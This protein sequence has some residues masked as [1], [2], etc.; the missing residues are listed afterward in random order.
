[1]YNL[2]LTLN[3]KYIHPDAILILNTCKYANIVHCTISNSQNENTPYKITI[4]INIMIVTQVKIVFLTITTNTLCCKLLLVLLSTA[5]PDDGVG[6]NEGFVVELELIEVSTVFLRARI[7]TVYNFLLN[8]YKIW[9]DPNNKIIMHNID[10][11][12]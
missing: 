1:M 7:M 5:D 10:P 3:D 12:I 9:S 6:D 2:E 8:I 11:I 4:N